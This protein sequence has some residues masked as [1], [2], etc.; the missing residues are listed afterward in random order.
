M[1]SSAPQTP[2]PWG[3]FTDML[4][5]FYGYT[6][7]YMVSKY[8]VIP[9]IHFYYPQKLRGLGSGAPHLKLN[10]DGIIRSRVIRLATHKGRRTQ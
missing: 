7:V 9:S 1:G 10:L 5:Y 2:S 3:Y 6:H 8:M 4:A